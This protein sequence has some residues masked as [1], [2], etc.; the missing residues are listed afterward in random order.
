MMTVKQWIKTGLTALLGGSVVL[1]ALQ[2]IETVQVTFLFWSLQAPRALILGTVFLIGLTIGFLA[3][4]KSKGKR[5][6]P[7]GPPVN[8]KS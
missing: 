5:H 6:Q 8:P 4:R 3:T 7:E 2:N 1:F